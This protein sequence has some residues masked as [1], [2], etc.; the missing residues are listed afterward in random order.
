MAAPSSSVP[1]YN[2]LTP[3]NHGFTSRP[4]LQTPQVPLRN[5]GLHGGVTLLRWVPSAENNL[6]CF[7]PLPWDERWDKVQE[8]LKYGNQLRWR[9]DAVVVARAG[10]SSHASVVASGT[11]ESWP[12]SSSSS[13][14]IR[15]MCS[16]LWSPCTCEWRMLILKT[17]PFE[18]C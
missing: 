6:G 11:R 18:T 13:S 14:C 1:L 7:H 8:K 17:L 2:G 3:H 5:P 15:L 16:P 12:S 9:G 10:A 4:L